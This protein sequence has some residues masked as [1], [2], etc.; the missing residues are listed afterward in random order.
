MGAE[1]G[2]P[3]RAMV[4]CADWCNIWAGITLVISFCTI[5]GAFTFNWFKME[6]GW[7]SLMQITMTVEGILW[8]I[9]A[10]L[11]ARINVIVNNASV[12]V[13]Q[14]IIC[15]GGIFFAISGLQDGIPGNVISLSYVLAPAAS[16]KK[17]LDPSTWSPS[18][19]ASFA[20]AC[21]YYGISCFMVAT[22]MGLRGVWGLPKTFW[23]PFGAIACFFIGAW[24]IGVFGLWGP[25][26]L[27]GFTKYED[28]D[29]PSIDM[30]T[31]K[32][33]SWAWVH[34]MQVIGAVFLTLG[35]IVFGKLDDIYPCGGSK[36]AEF[37]SE[38]DSCSA[39]DSDRA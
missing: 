2:V 6:G 11:L 35:G 31:Q 26:I 13:G 24:T 9:A 17:C 4:L 8:A 38:D 18:M 33:F 5:A 36:G 7:H 20:D 32:T 25:T 3:P 21:P 37:D 39:V 19:S 14:V 34:V 22:A 23:S 10:A 30:Y 1:P 15:F 16:Q 12:A 27:D 29:N 28:L